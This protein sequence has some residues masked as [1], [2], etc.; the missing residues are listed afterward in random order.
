MTTYK[1]KRY[2]VAIQ[3]I[4]LILILSSTLSA[5]Q[6]SAEQ[7]LSWQQGINGYQGATSVL[8][9]GSRQQ[10]T[11]TTTHYHRWTGTS[12]RYNLE[13]FE[14]GDLSAYGEVV[15]ATLTFYRAGGYVYTPSAVH[16]RSIGD[17]DG[18]GLLYPN[19]WQVGEGFRAGANHESRDD[20]SSP[21]TKWRA[22]DPD[23]PD[24]L[25]ADYF[26]GV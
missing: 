24:D 19:G 17:P 21:D 15:S 16:A 23:S 20:T 13:H 22:S 10:Q 4:P 25:N 2:K 6:A 14:L 8:F 5:S 18:L 12:R 11:S 26:Q 9:G 3:A 1:K 7:T